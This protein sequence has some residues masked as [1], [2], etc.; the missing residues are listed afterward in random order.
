V[1][2]ERKVHLWS[3]T[4]QDKKPAWKSRPQGD[5]PWQRGA[6][7]ALGHGMVTDPKEATCRSCLN[8]RIAHGLPPFREFKR[9][10]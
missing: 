4:L 8:G 7:G 3:G 1:D 6:C 5:P 10:G 9:R 2:D